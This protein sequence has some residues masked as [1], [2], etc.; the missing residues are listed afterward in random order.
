MSGEVGLQFSSGIV[1]ALVGLVAGFVTWSL[2]SLGEILHYLWSHYRAFDGHFMNRKQL[3][4]R[5]LACVLLGVWFVAITLNVLA[6]W[7]AFR[8][9]ELSPLVVEQIRPQETM[10]IQAIAEEC[11]RISVLM[12]R[13][14]FGIFG[15][16]AL[17]MLAWGVCKDAAPEI[18]HLLESGHPYKIPGGWRGEVEPLWRERAEQIGRAALQS[19]AVQ[20]VKLSADWSEWVQLIHEFR[21]F[22]SPQRSGGD[23]TK[24]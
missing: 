11:S 4:A 21:H 19:D 16:L 7:I 22:S 5:L 20:Q 3:R 18:P 10:I 13:L 12:V 14:S 9:L 17:A 8:Y 2:Q 15:L 23:K 24:G 6:V 1:L